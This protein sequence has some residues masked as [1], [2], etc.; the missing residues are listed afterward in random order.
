MS[1]EN[2]IKTPQIDN[3]IITKKVA[4]TTYRHHR[5]LT[6]LDAFCISDFT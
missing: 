2:I 5:H 4:M 6:L 1:R 3:R